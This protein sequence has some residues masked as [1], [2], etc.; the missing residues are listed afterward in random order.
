[1]CA[2]WKL[3]AR[4]RGDADANDVADDDSVPVAAAFKSSCSDVCY[5]E[6]PVW[7]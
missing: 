5:I 6:G 2:R 7:I 3:L 1:M 4:G